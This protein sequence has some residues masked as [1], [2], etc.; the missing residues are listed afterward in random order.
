MT[1][2]TT[3]ALKHSTV[4]V[5]EL[6]NG[7]SGYIERARSGE[8]ITV[9]MHGA[10]V[11]SLRAVGLEVNRRQALI[12]TGIVIPAPNPVRSLPERVALSPG[13]SVTDLVGD[14]R[15]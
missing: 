15:R 6:K 8:E 7:L 11:V 3:P 4:G 2:V 5:R 1:E 10:P 14:Q 13:S 12:D 9:T